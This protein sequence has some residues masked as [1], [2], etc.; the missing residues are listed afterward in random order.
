MNSFKFIPVVGTEVVST[1]SGEVGI[2]HAYLQEIPPKNE[3]L[4]I[5]DGYFKET[6]TLTS[7]YLYC[8][9]SK[10][11]HLELMTDFGVVLTQLETLKIIRP[12]PEAR[13]YA[14]NY[15]P[16]GLIANYPASDMF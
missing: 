16:S 2:V 13:T 15:N 5:Y 12:H 8:R 14:E 10:A 11:T 1:T 9:R 7:Q 6:D 3:K 4:E